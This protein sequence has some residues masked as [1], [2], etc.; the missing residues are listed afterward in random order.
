MLKLKML[1]PVQEQ[2]PSFLFV[3]FVLKIWNI[4][5][6]SIDSTIFSSS[7]FKK[8]VKKY[9]N[10]IRFEW[11]EKKT[12]FSSIEIEFAY[13]VFDLMLKRTIIHT[14]SDLANW[15]GERL[16]GIGE[17]WWRR[18]SEEAIAEAAAFIV[19][20]TLFPLAPLLIFLLCW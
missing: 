7:D 17:D 1:I 19:S 6:D 13:K 14:V 12:L 15:D 9:R 20:K 11:S 16:T 4:S 8:I 10:Q 3:S 18:S 5:T 2:E